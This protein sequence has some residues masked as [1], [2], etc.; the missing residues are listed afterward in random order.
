M[1]TVLNFLDDN[2]TTYRKEI[3][4]IFTGPLE[5]WFDNSKYGQDFFLHFI[6]FYIL[7]K[8]TSTPRGVCSCFENQ[9]L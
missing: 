6:G 9:N 5:G 8:F 2:P 1:V 3:A 4:Q 7:L